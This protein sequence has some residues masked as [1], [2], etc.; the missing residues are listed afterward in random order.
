MKL[1][2]AE[3]EMIYGNGSGGLTY[4][5]IFRSAIL[6]VFFLFLCFYLFFSTSFSNE[7]WQLS[8]W[9]IDNEQVKESYKMG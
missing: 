7:Y 5:D 9:Q 3:D 8:A 4:N 6:A 1:I 2:S